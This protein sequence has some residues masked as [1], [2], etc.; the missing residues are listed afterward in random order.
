VQ[1]TDRAS[2]QVITTACAF[3]GNRTGESGKRKSNER[4]VIRVVRMDELTQEIIKLYRSGKSM[5]QVGE[6]F[7]MSKHAVG[8]RL[9]KHGENRTKKQ[10]MELSIANG[11]HYKKREK[12]ER[13]NELPMHEI[14]AL[15]EKVEA[16]FQENPEPKKFEYLQ[17][18][19]GQSRHDLSRA[20]S[21]LAHYNVLV[22]SKKDKNWRIKKVERN[23]L[24]E[25]LSVPWGRATVQLD[26]CKPVAL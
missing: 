9:R 21:K 22:F 23:I 17:E 12:L 25:Q 10:S 7:G 11:T 5:A 4:N 18:A 2:T 20:L 24:Q 26:C 13:E 15:A 19:L 14:N 1:A 16:I 8:R 3:L 6:V